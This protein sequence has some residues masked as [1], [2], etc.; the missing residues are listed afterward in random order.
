MSIAKKFM[1]ALSG[2]LLVCMMIAIFSVYTYQSRVS[3]ERAA[4][5]SLRISQEAVRLLT[6]TDAIMSER[7]HSS[8]QLLVEEGQKL[9]PAQL[10]DRVDV[11]VGRPTTCC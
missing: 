1:L 2:I 11:N 4:N 8:M 3:T 5:D 9:G 7:V 10:G 6:V